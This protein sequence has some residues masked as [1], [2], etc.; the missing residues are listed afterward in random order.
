MEILKN[1]E[2]EQLSDEELIQ[3]LHKGREGLEDYLID[4]YKG[5]VPV[6]Y[7]HLTLPTTSRV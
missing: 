4:K 6:S 2:F 1:N 5:M 7:T 3:L